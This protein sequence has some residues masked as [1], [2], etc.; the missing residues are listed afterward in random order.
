MFRILVFLL[1]T[2]SIA[3]VAAAAEPREVMETVNR[4]AWRGIEIHPF[5]KIDWLMVGGS[6]ISDKDML[7]LSQLPALQA[8]KFHGVVPATGLEHLKDS[9]K[10]RSLEIGHAKLSAAQLREIGNIESLVSL[11][12]DHCGYTEEGLLAL[13]NLKKLRGLSIFPFSAAAAR[14]CA[15]ANVLFAT[16]YCEHDGGKSSS[17]PE[18]VRNLY[19][20]E[21]FGDEALAACKFPQLRKVALPPMSTDKTLA[22][23]AAWPELQTLTVSSPRVGDDSLKAICSVTQLRTL[24]LRGTSITARGIGELKKLEHLE[25]LIPPNG[26]LPMLQALHAA[27]LI[28]LLVRRGVQGSRLDLGGKDANAA[29]ELIDTQHN[30]GTIVLDR[31]RITT[32]GLQH[33]A[34]IKSLEEIS[35]NFAKVDGAE[36][37][38]LA[39]LPKLRHL[40]L[41]YGELDDRAGEGLASLGSLRELELNYTK[42]TPAI[43][44][45]LL[46]MGGL[47]HLRV[48]SETLNDANLALLA[49]HRRLHILDQFW[50]NM[51][52]ADHD[53]EIY[54]AKLDLTPA[55]EKSLTLFRDL[56][57]KT[58]IVP[59]NLTDEGLATLGTL[60]SLDH[61]TLWGTRY[62]DAGFQH[63]A[64]LKNLRSIVLTGG[65]VSDKGA[66]HLTRLPEMTR[67]DL[68]NTKIGD[69]TLRLA[70]AMPKLKSISVHGTKVTDAGL[71]RFAKARPDC[72]LAAPFFV[73]ER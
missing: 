19:C 3:G 30:I 54:A 67:L 11:R 23:L 61:L 28:H 13:G 29:L 17:S 49:K 44:P 37:K 16:W 14:S 62:T 68:E 66:Q 56:N 47:T 24:N 65:N 38:Q 73:R 2:W 59:R 4:V 50:H 27:K 34:K 1:L 31:S 71:R 15:K 51:Q 7:H 18:D 21:N 53:R 64:N 12:I 41:H 43:I 45:K 25:E 9:K 57:I 48:P 22:C 8:L 36:L 6:P 33:L 63:L 52:P 32:A 39:A 26:D 42:V 72:E 69:E 35:L 40:K 46:S 5:D 60:E 58:L 20:D 70:E 10:L 55:T